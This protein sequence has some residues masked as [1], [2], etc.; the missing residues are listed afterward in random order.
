MR[1]P[2][3]L[4]LAGMLS[5][6]AQDILFRDT[7]D[8]P[9]NRNI[10]AVLTGI[11]AGT[12]TANA[13]VNHNFTGGD[14]TGAGGF[15]VLLRI[16]DINSDLTDLANRFAGFCVGLN[17]TQAAGGNDI[18]AA[19]P[20]PIRGNTGNPGTA[21]CFIELDLNGNVK[22]WSDGIQR[23]TVAT[24]KSKGTLAAAGLDY[25]Y[26]VSDNLTVWQTAGVVE[27]SSSP[28]PASPGYEVVTL[29]LSPAELTGEDK[30]FLKIVAEP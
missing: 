14:I 29:A 30:L 17:A 3:I 28:L 4:L 13:F 23:A 2:I 10:D 16:L 9:D 15:S 6:H 18:G 19:S 25:E 24:G 22:L 26:Q 7:F 21:D 27:E 12:G 20:P 11:T 1:L 8:R 5:G